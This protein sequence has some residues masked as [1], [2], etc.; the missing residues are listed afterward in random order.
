MINIE[1]LGIITGIMKKCFFYKLTIVPRG[2]NA[3]FYVKYLHKCF[4]P[5]FKRFRG[6]LLNITHFRISI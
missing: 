4:T 5:I 3:L 1:Y 2:P 6:R